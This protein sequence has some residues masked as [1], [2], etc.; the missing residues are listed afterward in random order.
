MGAGL[1]EFKTHPVGVALSLWAV[2]LVAE[3]ASL[4]FARTVATMLVL[5]RAAGVSFLAVFV[6]WCAFAYPP[7]GW[8]IFGWLAFLAAVIFFCLAEAEVPA[9]AR[10]AISAAVPRAM[11]G[12]DGAGRAGRALIVAAGGDAALAAAGRVGWA[13]MTGWPAAWTMHLPLT[14]RLQPP[15]GL[16]E[17]AVP[18]R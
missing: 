8:L 4:L 9:L 13:A 15:L 2:V 11:L 18:P 6:Y 16:Y 1:V 3:Y 10:G 17:Q 12:V 14:D 5:S 7:V